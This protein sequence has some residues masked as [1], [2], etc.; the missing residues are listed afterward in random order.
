MIRRPMC[1][2]CLLLMVFLCISDWLG[3]PLIRGNPLPESVQMWV[4]K[5]PKATI[6]GEAV[7]SADTEI[8]QSV[9]L[10]NT[11]LIYKSKKFPLK[12]LEYF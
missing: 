11:Y 7:S 2:M 6:F 8:S 10:K 12:M 3:F 5:H 9:N 4:E 1:L